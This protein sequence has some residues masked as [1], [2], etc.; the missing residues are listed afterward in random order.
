MVILVK[1]AY[2]ISNCNPYIFPLSH[3]VTWKHKAFLH[4]FK[5]IIKAYMFLQHTQ[6]SV[7]AIKVFPV[8]MLTGCSNSD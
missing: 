2:R 7:S 5:S 6:S 3:S 4:I 8:F 1:H